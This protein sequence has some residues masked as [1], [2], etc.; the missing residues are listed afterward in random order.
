M[1]S[2][3][4]LLRQVEAIAAIRQT[5]V[6][7]P[8]AHGLSLWVINVDFKG[9]TGRCDEKGRLDHVML[10]SMF[11]PVPSRR[12]TTN[13]NMPR[14]PIGAAG[15]WNLIYI[16]L[17]L[18]H[19][20]E[21]KSG[22]DWTVPLGGGLRRLFYLGEQKMGFQTQV[23]DYVARKPADPEWEVRMTIEFLFGE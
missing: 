22:E 16:F 6:T 1:P 7:F 9:A 8:P 13:L 12:L 23:F 19:S 15:K 5:G 10:I 18:S 14:T 2:Y 17:G 4:L 21:A 20:W 3:R 11:Q